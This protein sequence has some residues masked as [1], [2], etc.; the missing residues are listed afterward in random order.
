MSF[1]VY[2]LGE[3]SSGSSKLAVKLSYLNPVSALI[4]ERDVLFLLARDVYVS[5]YGW[6]EAI[7]GSGFTSYGYAYGALRGGGDF[8]FSEIDIVDVFMSYGVVGVSL[9]FLLMFTVYRRGRELDDGLYML[10]RILVVLF[11]VTGSL[12]GHIYL[13]GFPVF[14]FSCYAGLCSFGFRGGKV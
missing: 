12:T 13:M 3:F 10:R 6:Y 9:L 5:S 11:V 2:V 1:L 8:S 14:F 4:S 7:F